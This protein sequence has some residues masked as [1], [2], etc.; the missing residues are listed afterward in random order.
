MSD[1]RDDLVEFFSGIPHWTADAG[2]S[3]Q[4]AYA[5][6]DDLERLVEVAQSAG[7][8]PVDTDG[9]DP[10][11]FP[12]P[13]SRIAAAGNQLSGLLRALDDDGWTHRVS[14]HTVE[15][16]GVIVMHQLKQ[17]AAN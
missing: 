7:Y 5:V 12:E 4:S 11:S 1:L 16:H 15:E 14:D 8:P 13:S 10:S 6:A 2:L 3:Q 17:R 9:P